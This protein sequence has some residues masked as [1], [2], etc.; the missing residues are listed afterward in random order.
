MH[1]NSLETYRNIEPKL[2]KAEQKVYDT[3]KLL[4]QPTMN[5]VA[6]YLEKRKHAIS[7]RFTAL[8]KAFLIKESG[9]VLIN[10]YRNS[11]YDVV[12]SHAERVALIEKRKKELNHEYDRLLIDKAYRI[13]DY[14]KNLINN[15]RT[16]IKN[17]LKKI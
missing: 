16:A 6:N 11:T 13:S 9:Y 15:R 8:K 12:E 5:D 4:D 10:G 1:A 17:E 2:A 7:G 14:T 3:I